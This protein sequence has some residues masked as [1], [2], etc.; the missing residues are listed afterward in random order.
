MMGWTGNALN[1]ETAKAIWE[2]D[3]KVM[4]KDL[5]NQYI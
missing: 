2:E 1:Q 4:Y 5:W 3:I